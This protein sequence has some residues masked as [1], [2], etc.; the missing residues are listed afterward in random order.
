MEGTTG[1]PTSPWQPGKWE[2]WDHSS[3]RVSAKSLQLCHSLAWEQVKRDQRLIFQLLGKATDFRTFK[4]FRGF[5][6][7]VC[8]LLEFQVSQGTSTCLM[9]AKSKCIYNPQVK[10]NI[11]GGNS[12]LHSQKYNTSTYMGVTWQYT[13]WCSDEYHNEAQGNT[14]LLL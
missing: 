10:K 2:R 8:E 5:K 12:E 3:Q 6:T 9:D 13:P 7:F 1:V 11:F 14:V 4:L